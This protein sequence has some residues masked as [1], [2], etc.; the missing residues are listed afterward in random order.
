MQVL[1][2]NNKNNNPSMQALFF[3][4][5][6]KESAVVSLQIKEAIRNNPFIS[7]LSANTNVLARFIS[8][9]DGIIVHHLRLDVFDMVTNEEVASMLYSS[10]VRESSGGKINLSD[11]EFIRHIKKPE[12]TIEIV[13]KGNWFD[14]LFGRKK[15]RIETIKKQTEYYI[16]RF[17][18]VDEKYPSRFVSSEMAR[19]MH[20]A[21]KQIRAVNDAFLSFI[22]R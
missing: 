4:K 13:Q 15:E 20:D 14:R 16:F 19:Q 10:R 11:T 18:H 6:P 8:S 5:V 12:T 1:S 21:G 7:R 2:I 22:S 3:P 9:N 17:L